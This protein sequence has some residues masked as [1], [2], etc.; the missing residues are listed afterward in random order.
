MS[1]CDFIDIGGVI[2][3]QRIYMLA[4]TVVILQFTGT[5]SVSRE[6]VRLSRSRDVWIEAYQLCL[7]SGRDLSLR[8][9]K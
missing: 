6:L 7:H 9:P 2:R 5:M 3:V 8:P 1:A 4:S